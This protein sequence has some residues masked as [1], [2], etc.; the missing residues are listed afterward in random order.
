MDVVYEV[1]CM[2]LLGL[3]T[4]LRETNIRCFTSVWLRRTNQIQLDGHFWFFRFF[5]TSV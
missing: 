5:R 1:L 3:F 2:Y 4:K